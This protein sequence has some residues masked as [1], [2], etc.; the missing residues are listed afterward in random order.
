MSHFF[1]IA[2]IATV[3]SAII[4]AVGVGSARSDEIP[5]WSAGVMGGVNFTDTSH[6]TINDVQDDY[7]HKTGFAAGLLA[8][9][10]F[11]PFR[12]Q[13]DVLKRR[14]SFDEEIYD[15]D[16]YAKAGSVSSIAPMASVLY[17]IPAGA[18][19]TP[20]VGAGVGMAKV[21]YR[22][23]YDPYGDRQRVGKWA[24]AYQAI[25]GLRYEVAANW[26]ASAEY[27]Y[28]ATEQKNYLDNAQ[29]G[30]R[31]Y[32]Y[33]NHAILFGLTYKFGE[34]PVAPA[35]V[36]AAPPPPPAPP[37]PELARSYLVFFDWNSSA[38]TSEA[39][40]IIGEAA[41][42]AQQLAVTRVELT[43]HADR[44]GSTAYNQQ[45]SEKRGAAVKNALVQ[46]GVP[47]AQITVVGKGEASPLVPTA[48]GV[49]E[50]Q[51][52]RVEIVLP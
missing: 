51:N 47:A 5:G 13:L 23:T 52:R 26:D 14:N 2:Q 44:S 25:A 28:F 38:V 9:Y 40:G 17:D 29:T 37:A 42:A 1:R 21:L 16:K 48:D 20:Y 34:A 22:Y 7:T 27:R 46:L 33:G 32:S 24:Y 30:T 35:P 8:V 18:G 36:V 43:G 12:L 15:G 50:P 4:L 49:R 39:A 10:D 45:L 11:G 6:G 3:S 31:G 19:L 41:K